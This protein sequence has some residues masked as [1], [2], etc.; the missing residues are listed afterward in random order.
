MLTAAALCNA[1]TE[2]DRE[3]SGTQPE[4]SPRLSV[5]EAQAFFEKN[6]IRTRSG[7]EASILPFVMGATV[8]HWEEAEASVSDRLSSVDI[9]A[10]GE[11]TYRVLRAGKDG[12]PYEVTAWSK[13]IVVKSHLTDSLATCIRVSIPDEEYAGDYDGNICNMSLNCED[14]VD[15]CGLEYYAALDGYPVAV[16]RYAD[17]KCVASVYLFDE[18]LSREEIGRRY[19]ALFHDMWIFRDSK[20]NGV[21]T[22]VEWDYGRPGSV[23]VDSKGSIY[24]YV[25]IDGDGKSDAI[26]QI[27]L[28]FGP[29]G[30]DG[31]FSSSGG[32]WGSSGN[33][34]ENKN[35]NKNPEN[36]NSS[37]QNSDSK[38][39][40]NSNI[41]N[42]Y[43][44]EPVD[45][46]GKPINKNKPNIIKNPN[47]GPPTER[48]DPTP[49][50]P[51]IDENE[52]EKKPCS[53]LNDVRS[54]PLLKM[55]I[56]GTKNNGKAGGR[57]GN[58]RDRMHN[59]ID[60]NAAV[61]TPLY[62]MFDG[63]II[64]IA[65]KYDPNIAYKDYP[66]QY[67][68]DQRTNYSAG[69]RVWIKSSTPK[70]TVLIK[71]FHL[72]DV[73]ATLGEIKAGS[74][75]GHTG[76]T[77]SAGAV[78]SAGPHLHMEVYVNNVRVNPEE[79][80]FTIFDAQGN[81]ITSDCN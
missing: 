52:E 69:N 76:Q 27:F 23:F 3:P 78:D 11:F 4:K 32:G 24:V 57:Y 49:W 31:P 66:T 33:D 21:R 5:T 48:V 43:G 65:D 59:G 22:R 39:D 74:L 70:G 51:S 54:N 46:Y 61:G 36:P 29:G 8:L 2:D 14:R 58:A 79:F 44:I 35:D 68:N 60:L 28:P 75:I 34:S 6:A 62:A 81:S 30:T 16:A 37:G 47:I 19:A 71:Y 7:E 53:N 1:C 10:E 50:Q 17:G 42:H 15:Y 38:P 9:P 41:G 80:L 64:R 67:P 40:G 20:N 25:D 77:G 26:T 63:I 12:T 45:V 18:T 73:S 55:E 72:N 13:I 56:L